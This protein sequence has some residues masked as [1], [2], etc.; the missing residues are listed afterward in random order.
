LSAS[1]DGNAGRAFPYLS[2]NDRIVID[3]AIGEARRPGLLTH[4]SRPTTDLIIGETVG[5]E[6]I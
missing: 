4:S 3:L 5:T 6:S 1:S 2:I